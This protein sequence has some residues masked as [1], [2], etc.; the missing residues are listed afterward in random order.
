M[1]GNSLTRTRW[2][3]VICLATD[4]DGWKRAPLDASVIDMMAVPPDDFLWA[5]CTTALPDGQDRFLV[6]TIGVGR[7]NAGWASARVYLK[8]VITLQKAA[9][10]VPFELMDAP[11]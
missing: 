4:E 7:A 10:A 3:E 6:L 8:T 11:V 2:P 9:I 1:A 5:P